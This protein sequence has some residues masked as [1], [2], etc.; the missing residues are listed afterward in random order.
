MIMHGGS[1]VL[2]KHSEAS[3]CRIL[4]ASDNCILRKGVACILCEVLS[5]AAIA[6]VSCFHDARER[7]R[8]EEFSAAIFD[9]DMG[10]LNGPINL[11]MLRDDHARLILGVISHVT[12][13]RHILSYLA[14]GVNGYI[15]GCSSQDRKSTRL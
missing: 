2:D 7:L 9:I 13:S 8:C 1:A 10:D 12:T 15:L 5:R 11:Q 14:A 4:V 3:S 6:E